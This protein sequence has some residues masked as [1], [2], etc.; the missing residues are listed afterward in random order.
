[1]TA[2]TLI[3]GI[4]AKFVAKLE[5]AGI[6]STETLLSKCATA[7]GR[8]EIAE[9]TGINDGQLLQWFHL[10]VPHRGIGPEYADLL[11]AAGVDS[12]LGWLSASRQPVPSSRANK[13]KLVRKLSSQVANWVEQAKQLPRSSSLVKCKP[14]LLA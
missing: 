6:T 14:V 1:M 13:T 4:S 12:A 5:A 8:K 7:K 9:K 10:V 3:E 11:E 2:L